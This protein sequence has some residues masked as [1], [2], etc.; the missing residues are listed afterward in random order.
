[1]RIKLFTLLLHLR[2]PILVAEMATDFP[3][4]TLLQFSSIMKNMIQEFNNMNFC[5][6]YIPL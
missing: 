1:M 3:V 6:N 4:D 2:T 5:P